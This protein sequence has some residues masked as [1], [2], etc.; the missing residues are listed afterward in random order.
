MLHLKPNRDCRPSPPYFAICHYILVI[1]INYELSN[2]RTGLKQRKVY[3]VTLCHCSDEATGR[4]G[5]HFSIPIRGRAV[6]QPPPPPKPC[7][8]SSQPRT[9]WVLWIRLT[10][11][12][13]MPTRLNDGRIKH[14]ADNFTLP[15]LYLCLPSL[16][17]YPLTPLH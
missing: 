14:R 12:L 17:L 8:E 1:P 16:S 9:V 3:D 2:D 11:H 13:Q 10:T 15:H 7:M 6:P 4:P 5:S